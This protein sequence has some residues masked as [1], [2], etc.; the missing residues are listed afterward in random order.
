MTTVLRMM[1]TSLISL[2]F[3]ELFPGFG[4]NVRPSIEVKYKPSK[5]QQLVGARLLLCWCVCVLNRVKRPWTF[6]H[7]RTQSSILL[8]RLARAVCDQ[9]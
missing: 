7:I 1:K 3:L 8:D 9:L 4:E 5:L 2:F 6:T